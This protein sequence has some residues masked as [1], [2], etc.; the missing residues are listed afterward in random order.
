MGQLSLQNFKMLLRDSLPV[1]AHNPDIS[2]E[3]ARTLVE[4]TM[5]DVEENG[6]TR[7]YYST[8]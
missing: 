8:M 6:A 1:L 5:Q 3:E 4:D 7:T 2:P